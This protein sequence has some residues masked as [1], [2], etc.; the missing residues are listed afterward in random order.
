MVL[1]IIAVFNLVGIAALIWQIHKF[2][3]ESLFY[4]KSA[5]DYILKLYKVVDKNFKTE[6]EILNSITEWRKNNG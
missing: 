6:A 3:E 4:S 2:K 1:I 5:D